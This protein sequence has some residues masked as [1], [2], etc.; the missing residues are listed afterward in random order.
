MREKWIRMIALNLPYLILFYLFN[1]GAWLFRHC[2]GG[3]QLERVGVMLANFQLAF[4][5]WLPSL[6]LTDLITGAVA[7][8]LLKLAVVYREKNA[9]KFRHGEEYGSARW[10]T[11]KDIEP[12]M[13][14][15]FENNIILTQTERLTMNNRPKQPKYARNKNVIVIGGSGSGKTR[16]YV[17]PSAPVRAV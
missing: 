8:V 5:D 11:L 6:Y 1:R 7:A 12:F 3:N 13:D 14:P 16:F 10:G 2:T 15:V 4:T 9:K 17:K